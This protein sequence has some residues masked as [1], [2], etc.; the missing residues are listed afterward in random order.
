MNQTNLIED[1]RL[2]PIPPWYATPW[3]IGLIVVGAAVF[4]WLF[5]RWWSKRRPAPPAEERIPDGP[6]VHESFLRRLA[7]LRGR[8]PSLSAYDLSIAV[9][10][11]LREYLEARFRYRILYQTTREFLEAV[12]ADAKLPTAQRERLNEFLSMCDA[13]KFARRPASDEELEGLLNTAEQVIREGTK[14]S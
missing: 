12:R 9:S 10:N 14:P 3:G 6:P 8:R 4:G 7:E 2:L 1:F 11:I 5:W 13:V